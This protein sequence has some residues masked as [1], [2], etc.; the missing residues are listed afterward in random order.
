M[1]YVFRIASEARSGYFLDPDGHQPE[2]GVASGGLANDEDPT[3]HK[4]E[5]DEYG[6]QWAP[7]VFFADDA[8]VTE[9]QRRRSA[10]AGEFGW[11]REVVTVDGTQHVSVKIQLKESADF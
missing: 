4:L 6:R 9:S 2:T 10:Q 3:H 1:E 8:I 5:S 7:K 11:V